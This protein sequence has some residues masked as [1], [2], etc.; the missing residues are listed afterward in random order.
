MQARG[1]AHALEGA[2]PR[3]ALADLRQ[4]GHLA[5]GPFDAADARLR[6]AASA[7]SPTMPCGFCTVVT[8][9]LLDTS[10]AHLWLQRTS[11]KTD[12]TWGTAILGGGDGSR[13]PSGGLADTEF[14]AGLP[15]RTPEQAARPLLD[16]RRA[17]NLHQGEVMKRDG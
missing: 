9:I 5:G 2:L 15:W 11:V 16:W 17:T 6:L 4:H 10:G 8:P 13:H 7:M 3:E 14:R 12:G 1:H